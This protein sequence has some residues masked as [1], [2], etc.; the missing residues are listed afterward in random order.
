MSGA[1]MSLAFLFSLG[2]VP[3]ALA[4]GKSDATPAQ[5]APS[6][7]LTGMGNAVTADETPA[8]PTGLWDRS[9]LLGDIGGI[10]PWLGNYGVT[11]SLQ[12]T[13]E[14]LNNLSGGV[15]RDGA[16]D[17]VT[18]LGLAVDTEKALGLSGGTF[19]VSALAGQTVTISFSGTEDTS[20]QTSFV[21]DDMS[22]TLS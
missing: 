11:V 4:Q 15:K 2:V 14:Y 21:L 8:A 3:P 12:E 13:S 6:T 18:Q 1:P 20:L 19:N 16:Y 22:L 9:N 10:R 7:P 5:A 17:G